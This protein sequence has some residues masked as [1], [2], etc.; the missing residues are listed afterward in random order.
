MVAVAVV[1][2][3]D[4]RLE[5]EY[6]FG[7]VASVEVVHPALVNNIPV[8]VLVVAQMRAVAPAVLIMAI[9]V[10]QMMALKLR[11]ILATMLLLQQ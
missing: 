11:G 10:A 7:Q 8:V 1:R 5:A 3:V 9:L 4:I 6:K 2:V